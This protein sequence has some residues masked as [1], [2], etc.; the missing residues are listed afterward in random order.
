MNVRPLNYS[1]LEFYDHLIDLT[2]FSFSRQMIVRRFAANASAI[3]K[4]MNVV[5]AISSEGYGRIRYYTEIRNRLETDRDMRRFF[6]QETTDIPEFF[7]QRIKSDL[8]PF[9]EWL[10]AGALRYDPNAYL[11][12]QAGAA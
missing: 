9:W 2:K 7:V 1:W 6:E 8:G 3:P 12:M 10:P 5:R 4:W 11:G